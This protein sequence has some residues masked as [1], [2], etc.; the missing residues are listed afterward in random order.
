MRRTHLVH[1]FLFM[2]LLLLGS[3]Q[4]HAQRVALKSNALYWATLSPNLGAEFRVSRHYTFN[5]EVGG[6]PFKLSDKFQTRF[7]G[8]TP[9]VRY[10]FEGRPHARHFMGLMGMA[11]AYD[12]VLQDRHHTG[13]AFGGGL[14]YGYSFVLGKRWSLETTVGAGVLKIREK[15]YATHEY[16][17]ETA[18]RNKV[19]FAPLKLGVTFVYLIK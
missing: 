15:N 9:E 7:A 12:L 6:N 17:P 10:W 11:A 16:A 14:T 18:N 5:L 8:I 3:G 4:L 13:S 19:I 1:K 2:L